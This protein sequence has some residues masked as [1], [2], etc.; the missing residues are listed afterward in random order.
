MVFCID[1]N[2]L[3][4]ALG[5]VL[6]HPLREFRRTDAYYYRAKLTQPGERS[7][8]VQAGVRCAVLCGDAA[9]FGGPKHLAAAIARGNRHSD[10]H[11]SGVEDSDALSGHA[12]ES[13][14]AYCFRKN[15]GWS[16]RLCP[17]AHAPAFRHFS[18]R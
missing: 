14:L 13:F 2:S 12:S 4:G 6:R 7:G 3:I 18:S 10:P 11:L 8:I 9:V 5:N 1:I 17:L 16:S 15:G